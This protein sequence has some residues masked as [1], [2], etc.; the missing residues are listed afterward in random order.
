[1]KLR[2]AALAILTAIIPGALASPIYILNDFNGDLTGLEGWGFKV[3]RLFGQGT[4]TLSVNDARDAHL[5]VMTTSG[6]AHL[7]ALLGAANDGSTGT[8]TLS[9]MFSGLT[10]GADGLSLQA[11]FSNGGRQ[12][13]GTF[14]TPEG[15]VF[16]VATNGGSSPAFTLSGAG[17]NGSG[18]LKASGSV[19]FCTD[20]SCETVLS[21]ATGTL[22]LTAECAANSDCAGLPGGKQAQEISAPR[23]AGSDVDPVQIYSIAVPP[24]GFDA[25][26]VGKTA[27]PEVPE[28]ATY[29]LTGAGLIGLASYKRRKA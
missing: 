29:F 23:F 4:R 26:D 10:L 11:G 1:M 16:H 24:Q 12:V 20:A 3:E 18:R 8:Y 6:Q 15:Q 13:L 22:S 17:E 2:T 14:T 27:P 9:L 5:S 25:Q 21:D 19:S 28:P 7:L